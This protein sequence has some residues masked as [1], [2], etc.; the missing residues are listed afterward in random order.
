[1]VSKTQKIYW[2]RKSRKGKLLDE[3]EQEKLIEEEKH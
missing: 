2:F 3:V 1:M